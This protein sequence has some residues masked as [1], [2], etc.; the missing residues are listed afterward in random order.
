MPYGALVKKV[1]FLYGAIPVDRQR[2]FPSECAAWFTWN[3]QS[4]NFSYRLLRSLNSGVGHLRYECPV[5]TENERLICDIHSHGPLSALFSSEDDRDD[6][7]EIKIAAVIGGLGFGN[8]LSVKF[9][10]CILLVL[11]SR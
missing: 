10:L 8:R 4:R 3:T 6:R 11:I 1:E 5:L 9:R 7:G 2:G